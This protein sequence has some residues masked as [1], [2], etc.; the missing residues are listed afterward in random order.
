MLISERIQTI[1]DEKHLNQKQFAESVFVTGGYVSRILKNDIGM[2]NSQALLIERVHGYAKEW[3]L[4]G[5][6]P[7]RVPKSAEIGLTVLQ[8]QI[9]SDIELM[10][11]E[12]LSIIAAYIEALKRKRGN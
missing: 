6:G 12:E 9:I 4:T 1:I 2:S 8:K 5:K 3:I 10:T 11:D 7:K